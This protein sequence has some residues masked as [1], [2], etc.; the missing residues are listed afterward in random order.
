MNSLQSA[1]LN[2][3]ST[4]IRVGVLAPLSRP[5]WIEAGEHLRAGIELGARDINSAGGILGRPIELL[6]RD[7]AADPQKAKAAVEDLAREGVVALVGEFHSVVARAV[8]AAAVGLR[9]PFICSSAVIDTLIDEPSDL[10]ARISPPQSKGWRI[11]AEYLASAGRERIAVVTQRS[12]YWESGEA[13]L[14]RSLESRG[15]SVVAI[16]AATLETGAFCSQL[17]SARASALLLLVGTPDPAVA[18]VRL[19]RGHRRFDQLLLAAPAGQPELSEWRAVLGSDGGGT[20]FLR[21]LPTELSAVGKYVQTALLE[22]L[23]KP[24]FFVGFEGY[25]AISILADAIGSADQDAVPAAGFWP[26]VRIDGTRGSIRLR[27]SEGS[28][29][30]QWEDAPVQIADRNP[31]DVEAFR[32]LHVEA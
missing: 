1:I 25:D 19:V 28:N 15:G 32:I 27:R 5:G 30:W 22:Y 4:T 20:P 2:T 14:R 6:T 12:A 23:G 11:F 7:T 31:A 16:D 24:P 3:A 9:L 29:V 13:I 17:A 21:Y 26:G 18:I 8:A 10:I